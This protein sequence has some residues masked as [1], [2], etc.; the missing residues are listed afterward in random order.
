MPVQGDLV[1][2]PLPDLLQWLG[3]AGKSGTLEIERRKIRKR[4]L[5]RRGRI[6]ACASDDPTDMLGHW[7][8]A[9]GVIS[10]DTLRQALARQADRPGH[11]GSILVSLGVI[12]REDL[13]RDLMTKTEEAIF[14][15]F[16][17][18]DGSFRF[19]DGDEPD[20]ADYPVELRVEDVLLRGA[21]RY[22]EILRIRAV[23]NDAGLVLAR[24]SRV[25]P[26]DAIRHT[27][28]KTIYDLVNGERTVAEILLHA[29][30]SEFA[31]TRFLFELHRVGLVK[32]IGVRPLEKDEERD[33]TEP[34]APAVE[35]ERVPA[36]PTPEPEAAHPTQTDLEV[37]RKLMARGEFEAALDILDAAYRSEPG[38]DALRRLLAEA[39]AAF[40]EKAYRHYLPGS[41]LLFL[42]KSVSALTSEQLS[43]AEFFLISRIDGKWD[44]RSV[45]QIA[46][47]R[48]VEALRT[49]KR[50]RERGIV[51]LREAS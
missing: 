37:A 38:D 17:W 45:V 26:R 29:H 12:T 7:L 14:S 39:E 8:V 32:I 34:V 43:P 20:E 35:E 1:C 23:F 10:E 18:P 19:Q 42:K 51:D 48:E 9:R 25:P 2:M 44:V 4:I 16:E 30:G 50:L 36:A 33:E 49:L 27:M 6:T 40:I 11:L 46:P 3:G 21:Q 41:K 13:D 24:T 47:I 5:F 31:V 15:L 28:A 22:D